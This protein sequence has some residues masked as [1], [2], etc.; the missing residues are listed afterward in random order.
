MSTILD[1]KVARAFRLRDL[2]RRD[3][4]ATLLKKENER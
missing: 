4:R 1:S 3:V 2:R